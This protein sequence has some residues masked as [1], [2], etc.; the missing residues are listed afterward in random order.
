M[1]YIKFKH[2]GNLGDIIYSLASIK[3]IC[4]AYDAK[5]TL[6]LHLDQKSTFTDKTHPVGNVMLNRK[7]A[8]MAIPLLISQ[9]YIHA[10]EL[11]EKNE[12]VV[13]DY[14]LDLFREDYK[15][16]SGGNIQTWIQRSYPELRP[17]LREPSLFVMPKETDSIIINR[18]TRYNNPLID[19]TILEGKGNLI[20]VGVPDEY[21]LMRAIIPSLEYLEVK[22][23]LELAQ[24]IAGCRLFVGNQS[25]PFAIAESLKVHRVLEQFFG[26]PNVIPQ[27][28]VHYQFH[29]Q[30][31][32]Q[33]IINQL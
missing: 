10:I 17:N 8:E 5:A 26:A 31:Q 27:G 15:N 11:L 24:W 6:Y 16:L 1:N 19:Y 3:Y 28:G 14:D 20:F 33:N 18:S 25:M 2:S 7:M 23:F 4:E 9:P 12:K 30:K 13:V 32:F 21:K 22:D 29:S